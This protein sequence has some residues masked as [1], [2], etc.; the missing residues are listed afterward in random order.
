MDFD[1]NKCTDCFRDLRVGRFTCFLRFEVCCFV[2]GLVY[3]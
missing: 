1:G 2:I 3:M